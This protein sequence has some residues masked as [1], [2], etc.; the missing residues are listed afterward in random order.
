MVLRLVKLEWL[1]SEIEAIICV[2][3]GNLWKNV[4]YLQIQINIW[5]FY[6]LQM[7]NCNKY[8][9]QDMRG[10]SSDPGPALQTRIHF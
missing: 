7:T 3:V 1:F 4:C 10:T 5:S 9:L 2:F 8:Q 6:P